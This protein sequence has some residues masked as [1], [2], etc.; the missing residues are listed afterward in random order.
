ME[1]APHNAHFMFPR[2]FYTIMSGFLEER[3]EAGSVIAENP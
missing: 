3:K 1:K 2:E